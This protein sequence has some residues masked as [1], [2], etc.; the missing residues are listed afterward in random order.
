MMS[1]RHVAWVAALYSAAAV[2]AACTANLQIDNFAF[3]ANGTNSLGS[4]TSGKSI[5]ELEIGRA[6]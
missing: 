4:Q 6:C 2:S 5:N 3:F 1:V